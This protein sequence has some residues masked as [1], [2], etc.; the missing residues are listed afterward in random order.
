MENFIHDYQ[1]FL[2][3]KFRKDIVQFCLARLHYERKEYDAALQICS[4]ADYKD[5]LMN[6][7]SRSLMMKIYYQQQEFD[8]LES[9]LESFRNY[10]VRKKV[11]AYHKTN[12]KNIIRITKKLLKTNPYSPKEKDKLRKAIESTNPL[13]ER[14]WLLEQLDEMG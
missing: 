1:S 3:E 9:Y 13:T 10:V 7:Y 4:Q 8:A 14:T 12:Y 2:E 11:L 6:L 5:I